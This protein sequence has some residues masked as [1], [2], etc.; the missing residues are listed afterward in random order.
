MSRQYTVTSTRFVSDNLLSILALLLS[1]VVKRVSN[2]YTQIHLLRR[3]RQEDSKF[4]AS[5]GNLERIYLITKNKKD[6]FRGTALI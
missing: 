3:L 6:E 2:P 1:S 4:K 5:L